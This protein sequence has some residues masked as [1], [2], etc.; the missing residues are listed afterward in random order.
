MDDNHKTKRQLIDEIRE[1]RQTT[2]DLEASLAKDLQAEEVLKYSEKTYRNLVDN[3][4]VGI[5]KATLKGTFLYVNEALAKICEFESPEE[6][7]M[8]RLHEIYKAP[9]GNEY[10]VEKLKKTGRIS[11]YE[12]KIVTK[13]G[14]TKDILLNANLEGDIISGMV[15]D[16]TDRKKMEQIILE[17]KIIW[18]NTFNTINDMITV[19]DKDF[20]IQLANKA[21]RSYLGLPNLELDRSVK[22]FNYYHGTDCPPERCPVYECQKTGKPATL[23]VYEPH[24]NKFVEIRAI[25][26][27]D[28]NRM[29]G[30]IHVVRDITN[31][32]HKEKT[33]ERQLGRLDALRS[34]DRAIIGT[35]D[36]RIT[37]DI[38]LDQVI[39]QLNIDAASVL[40]LSQKTQ[41]L[42]YVVSKGFR[43]SSLKYTRLRLGESNAG[44]AAVERHIVTIPNL[45]EEIDGFVNSK[46]FIDEDFL[47]YF[48]VPLI[49][50]GQVKG[51]LELFHR[52]HLNANSEWLEFLEAIADQGAIAIEN[53]TMFED[54]QRSNIDLTMAYDTTIEGWSHAMDMRDKETEGHTQR[55]TE[56][57]L[58]MAQNLG[59][60]DEDLVHIRRG[61]LLHDMGKMGIPDSILLKPGPLTE[62]EWEIMKRHPE[63]AHE[64]LRQ[65]EYLRPALDIP[66]C[67]HEKWDGTGYPRGLK[68]EEIPLA[69][70]I[71]A[72]VDVWDAL[73]SD[74]PYRSAWPKDKVFEHIRSLSGTH[75]DP[76]VAEA[77]FMVQEVMG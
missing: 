53:A 21:A 5:N 33:I 47:A 74:R 36:M 35:L 32:K 40:L 3:S 37:L 28:N 49:A 41:I 61:A 38:F 60:R 72:I 66:Y 50:K 75:F 51:V 25:P 57:T 42:E 16:I 69:A 52:S 55:V 59:I 56:I 9:N 39:T 10:F 17:S 11:N 19:H 6:L 64:M 26:K 77:F 29:V 71:F 8:Q 48:A 2:A 31:L 34:I 23:E 20:N 27:F 62:E 67:H 12:L 15:M 18:E 54:I 22:C 63:Y 76:E 65:I 7:M 43:S 4:L 13:S 44:R 24:L 30:T 14:K 1:L 58:L 46:L 70:R 73:C 68:G 45:R